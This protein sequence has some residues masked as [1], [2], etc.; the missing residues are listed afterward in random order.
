M[1]KPF[2]PMTIESRE[3]RVQRYE[4]LDDACLP[5]SAVDPVSTS[6]VLHDVDLA[7]VPSGA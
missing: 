1:D 3:L 7:V 6:E 2:V 5:W 4:T